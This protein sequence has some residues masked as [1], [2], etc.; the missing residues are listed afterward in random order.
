MRDSKCR[1]DLA[2]AEVKIQHLEKAIEQLSLG[3][4]GD[5]DIA[6]KFSELV[7]ELGFSFDKE[8]VFIREAIPNSTLGKL[9]TQISALV[10][11]CNFEETYSDGRLVYKKTR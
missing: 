10:E 11:A 2:R 4:F 5:K 1:E 7:K 3:I 6:R 8:G 9:Q